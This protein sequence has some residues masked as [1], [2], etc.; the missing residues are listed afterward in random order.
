M[1]SSTPLYAYVPSIPREQNASACFA[2]QETVT[3]DEGTNCA[4]RRTDL[5]GRDNPLLKAHG[6][7]R[8]ARQRARCVPDRTVSD[9][10]R[11]RLCPRWWS[12][13]LDR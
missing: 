8:R 5:R 13:M 7:K 9:C 11:V 6:A 4:N 10:D 3:D 2:P 1:A 12:A